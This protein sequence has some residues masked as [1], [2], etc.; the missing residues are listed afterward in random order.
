MSRPLTGAGGFDAALY[1]TWADVTGDI[2]RLLEG[3]DGISF[4]EL[5]ALGK[6]DSAA[7]LPDAYLDLGAMLRQPADITLDLD[8]LEAARE[9]RRDPAVAAPLIE[10][11]LRGALGK[12]Y[13]PARKRSP[14]I[15]R[16]E[17]M[18][19][20]LSTGNDTF[21]RKLRYLLWLN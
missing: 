9:G 15:G 21:E 18:K 2:R 10:K 5:A 6:R 11:F 7:Y 19:R 4:R 17:R 12:G 14:L 13:A 20:E 1:Q 16:L 3:E 8:V